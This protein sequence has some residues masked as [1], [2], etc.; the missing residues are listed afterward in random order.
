MEKII[1]FIKNLFNKTP[2]KKPR[3]PRRKSKI[4]VRQDT[5]DL[6]SRFDYLFDEVNNQD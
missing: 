6:D 1:N 3:K 5:R 4:P 2:A